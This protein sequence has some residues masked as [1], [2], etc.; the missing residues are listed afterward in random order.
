MVIGG[1][2]ERVMMMR[3]RVMVLMVSVHSRKCLMIIRCNTSMRVGM[4]MRV[5]GVIE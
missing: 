2:R 5:D 3:I 4:A 1:I